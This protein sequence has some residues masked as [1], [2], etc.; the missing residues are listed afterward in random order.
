MVESLPARQREVLR[1]IVEL[2]E[3]RGFPPTLSDLAKAMGLKNRMTV[4]QHVTALK[5]KGLVHWEPGL[6]RSLR[7]LG[8][9]QQDLA[10]APPTPRLQ[11]AED[12]SSSEAPRN[13]LPL[14]GT[15]A[16]GRP[17]DAYQTDE[18]LEVES[19]YADSGCY[20]LKIK[21]DS[22]IDDGIY[23]GDFVIIKPNPSPTNGDIIVALL[24]DGTATLK[25]FFKEKGRFRLQPANPSMEPIYINP[26][27]GLDVQG[28]VVGLFRKF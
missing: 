25:R 18:Y 21:G 28:T 24:S 15:I 20:A 19:R 4:H 23:D 11:L 16:A 13:R 7:V 1:F 12:E 22:M 17:I 6:N 10:A 26:E 8:A 14:A 9:A 3:A 2:T 27:D 5:N